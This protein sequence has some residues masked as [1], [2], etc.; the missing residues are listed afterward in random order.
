MGF[1]Q[2]PEAQ[3]FHTQAAVE[4]AVIAATDWN[5]PSIANA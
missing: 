2:D 3:L 1:A 4:A 5:S